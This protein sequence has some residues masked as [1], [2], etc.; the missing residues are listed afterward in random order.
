VITRVAAIAANAFG[1]V[2]DHV[3]KP[4]ILTKSAGIQNEPG[5]LSNVT[6]PAGSMAPK[7]KLLKL[8]LMLFGID[9]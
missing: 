6:I 9:A 8:L 3:L 1:T 4:K 2:I 7:R 5:I